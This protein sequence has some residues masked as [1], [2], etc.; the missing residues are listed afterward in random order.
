MSQ[1]N[2]MNECIKDL[3]NP[4]D[5]RGKNAIVTGGNRGIGFGIAT[6]F[7]QRGASVAILCRNIEDGKRA[8]E[9]LNA[10]G[11]NAIA[12]HCNIT[13]TDSV[14]TAVQEVWEK[15]G[16][17]DVLVNNAGISLRKP[18]LELD[19]DMHEFTD[20]VDVNLV[21]AARMSLICGKRMAAAGGGSIINIT[22][23][24]GTLSNSAEMQPMA[25]YTSSK[26]A[27]NH[28]TRT[29]AV[30]LSRDNIRVN[31]VAPGPTHSSLEDGLSEEMRLSF[32]RRLCTRRFGEGLEI[33]AMCAYLASPEAAQICGSIIAVDGGILVKG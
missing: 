22:S 27:L 15:F 3:K 2:P 21:G 8:A 20:V 5:L 13:D 31:G 18:F 30:E 7:T 9:E 12:V 33:G 29:L 14:K 4:M 17:V 1:I 24:G 10:E 25:G 32:S 28:L 26:A 23:V 19:E 11:G 16:A 6:A